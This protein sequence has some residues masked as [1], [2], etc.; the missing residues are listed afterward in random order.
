MTSSNSKIE[1]DVLGILQRDCFTCQ[2]CGASDAEGGRERM[3]VGY[4]VRNDPAVK[5]SALDLKTLCP[6]CDDGFAK[7]KLLPRMNAA[8][9]VAELRRAMRADQLAVLG[10]MN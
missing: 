4:V 3:R 5:N 8:Q 10:R 1:I 9:I 6:D 7:A 2:T